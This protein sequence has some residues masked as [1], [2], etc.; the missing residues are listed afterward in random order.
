MSAA[1]TLDLPDAEATTAL[2]ARIAPHLRPGMAIL[3]DGPVGAGKSHFARAIIQSRMAR[4]GRHE[5]VPSPTYTL[6]QVYEAGGHEIWH[7]DLYRLADPREVAELGLDEAFERAICLVEWPDRLAAG[8]PRCALRL[9]LD[10]TAGGTGRTARLDPTGPGWDEV[11]RV[12][13]AGVDAGV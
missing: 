5:D 4:D 10:Y 1:L 3:L 6:V 11:M 13:K 2:A 8:A 9:G 7:A 12:A